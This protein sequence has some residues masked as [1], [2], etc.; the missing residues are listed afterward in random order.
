M[1]LY[2]QFNDRF[3]F[4]LAVSEQERHQVYRLRYQ[5]YTREFGH[6]MP[7][8]PQRGLEYDAFDQS[9]L[10]CLVRRRDTAEAVACIRVIYPGRDHGILASMPI[11]SNAAGYFVNP[12]LT[13]CNLPRRLVC[14]VSRAAILGKYRKKRA[15]DDHWGAAESGFP[16]SEQDYKVAS[17]LGVSVYLA[18][19]VMIGLLDRQHAFALMEPRLARLLRRFG[20]NFLQI[21]AEQQFNGIRAAYYVDQHRARENL[22]DELARFYSR[23]AHSLA[24]QFRQNFRSRP[25]AIALGR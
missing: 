7:G 14:E 1:S 17:L 10:H 9:A 20:L 22:K 23:I 11:E 5:I 6:E 15:T 16:S 8:D 3:E 24:G 25:R 13:P 18:S 4:V 21:G 19:T 12:L 2:D